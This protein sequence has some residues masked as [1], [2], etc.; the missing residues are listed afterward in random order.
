M[1]QKKIKFARELIGSKFDEKVS[2][3]VIESILNGTH[4]LKEPEKPSACVKDRKIPDNELIVP[5]VCFSCNSTC[6]VL[7]YKDKNT[8]RILRVEGDPDS[9]QTKGMLCSKGLAASE[10]VYN[11]RRLQK[12]LKRV[13]KRGEGKWEEI[14]WEEALDITAEKLKEHK[15]KYGPQSLALLEGT[16]RGWSRVYT[17]LVNLFHA[18]NHGAAGW[19]Q[20][21]WPRLIDC[22]L[23]YGGAQYGETFDFPN[24]HCIL[25]WGV[26]PPTCWGVRAADI[27][28]ARQRGA[29][30]IVIDPYFSETAAKADIWLQIRPDTD[31]ALALAFLHVVVSENLI[32]KE[33]IDE[34]T[35]G[36]N[37]IKTHVKKYTPEWA[38]GITG[39]S[40]DDI[41]KAAI[42]Y[43]KAEAAC[44]IRGL[45]LDQVHDSVQVCRATSILAA[46]TGNIGK[47]GGNIV[48]SS[49]GDINQNTHDFIHSKDIPE[50]IIK[51]RIGYEQYPLLTQELSPVPSA[52]M[53]SL[54]ETVL[55]GEP[56]PIK[57]AMI[58]GSNALLSYT[59]AR[60]VEEAI[61][62]LDF[63]A[64]C[65]LFLTPT[66]EQ[67][68]IVFPASSWLER[69][70]VISSFQSSNSYTLIEQKAETIGESR[71]DVDIII[72]LAK[73]LGLEEH[74]WENSDRYYDYLL[75]PTGYTFDEAAKMRRLYKPITYRAYEKNGFKTPTGKLELYS[76]LAERNHCDPVPQ[77]TPSFQSYDSTPELAERYPLIL[78][79][80]RHESAFRHSENRYQ[81]RLLELAP[82]AYLYI[83]PQT[84]K[85]LDIKDGARVKVEST[86]GW[87]YAF[88][89]YTEGLREDVV[90]GTAGWPGDYNINK[91]VPWGK[92]AQGVGT[93][94]ARGY[95]CNVM[96]ADK[97]DILGGDKHA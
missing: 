50:E 31:M 11:P 92:Y 1:E 24:T 14:S 71:H 9:P 33:F 43:A 93:V 3:K 66:G 95:L 97:T 18:P 49:R 65:D 47:K 56:Y 55:T 67:A 81:S 19:A 21:L 52:H 10:L 42:V 23:T 20:C 16:R 91:T 73:R 79:T 68:D 69:N 34:W 86:A 5:S 54:W 26:N 63:L 8:G 60:K 62:K 46:I 37:E 2:E 28:D 35:Y 82:K 6:E 48:T 51:L 57:C 41:K 94:C 77:Y 38:A 4:K 53:P 59:N 96:P 70:N 89:V 27:M 72:E 32:D 36:F 25:A 40:A 83:N 7:I 29:A 78:T 88:A 15:E 17:R 44:V 22:N 13:G 64:V 76:I 45:A 58:F 12:P 90:Q 74:F 61:S 39:V 30:L 85:K 87:A 80:G 84:A 75:S